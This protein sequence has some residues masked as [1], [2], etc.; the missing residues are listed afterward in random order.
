MKDFSENKESINRQIYVLRLL[1]IYSIKNFYFILRV[2]MSRK[3]LE[4]ENSSRE[5][6]IEQLENKLKVNVTC[7]VIKS[8]TF[9][10]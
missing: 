8:L 3:Q 9:H 5:D 6:Q 4:Y 10:N 1:F 2:K 7:R